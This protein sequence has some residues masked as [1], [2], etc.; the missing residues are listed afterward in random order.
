MKPSRLANRIKKLGYIGGDGPYHFSHQSKAIHLAET[1]LHE[2]CHSSLLN[3]A[4]EDDIE[5]E[6]KKLTLLDSD[7]NE[8]ETLAVEFLT[9]KRYGLPITVNKLVDYA[10]NGMKTPEYRG[11]KT[12]K[13]LVLDAM[14]IQAV[15]DAVK[16]VSI[17]ILGRTK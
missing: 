4:K 9:A 7:K 6:I 3:W 2:M 10:M 8:T 5:E 17:K 12:L 14:K 16:R 1:A 15:K 11:L 13:K